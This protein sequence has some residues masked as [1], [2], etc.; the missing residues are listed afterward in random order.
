[1]SRFLKKASTFILAIF[2]AFNVS[3][4]TSFAGEYF[5][6]SHGH[7]HSHSHSRSKT[8]D[9]LEGY[10][11][12]RSHLRERDFYRF[13]DY[14]ELDALLPEDYLIEVDFYEDGSKN[15]YIVRED[16]VRAP[17]YNS[18]LSRAQIE[19]AK[20]IIK[21]TPDLS[22]YILFMPAAWPITSCCGLFT[23]TTRFH[24]SSPV[25]CN[26]ILPGGAGTCGG[27]LRVDIFY[28]NAV[29]TRC[30]GALL[31]TAGS[32]FW[33]GSAP[34]NHHQFCPLR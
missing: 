11:S 27:T 24:S 26:G 16:V 4:V 13:H 17:L 10:S 12:L 21:N 5:Y 30:T 9:Y 14:V 31:V 25:R 6:H 8:L 23:T 18:G 19:F 32:P 15:I 1:M 22:E 28:I 29:V 2:I 3:S 7:F 20:Q 33:A 34:G